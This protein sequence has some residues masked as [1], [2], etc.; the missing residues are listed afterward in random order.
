MQ[1]L[2]WPPAPGTASDTGRPLNAIRVF[3]SAFS[4]DFVARPFP[5][6]LSVFFETSSGTFYL[7]SFGLTVGYFLRTFVY[8]RW[9]R[10]MVLSFSIWG[11]GGGIGEYS[12]FLSFWVEVRRVPPSRVGPLRSNLLPIPRAV[13]KGSGALS[14][15]QSVFFTW[16][17]P[18]HPNQLVL[19]LVE[20]NCT[21]RQGNR[22]NIGRFTHT[23]HRHGHTLQTRRSVDFCSVLQGTGGPL[24]HLDLVECSTSHRSLTCTEGFSGFQLG[25]PSNRAFYY[26]R[27]TFTL[28]GFLSC[29]FD[30]T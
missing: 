2:K 30:R 21:Y 25:G 29:R 14:N 3:I 23:F 5:G 24:F 12:F 16:N 9:R 22:V 20:S 15:N 19:R 7:L 17:G 18:R 10:G 26:A 11:D 27:K 4:P 13:T 28:R 6:F 1:P 8:V